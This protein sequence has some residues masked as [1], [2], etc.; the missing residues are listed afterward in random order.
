MTQREKDKVLLRELDERG[1]GLTPW[2]VKLVESLHRWLET[3]DALT[4]PQ[5]EKLREIRADRM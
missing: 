3:N 1:E 2:E 4:D 5:R